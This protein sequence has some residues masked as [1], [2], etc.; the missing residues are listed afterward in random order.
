MLSGNEQEKDTPE[1]V[2]KSLYPQ[3]F[4]ASKSTRMHALN[5]K[6]NTGSQYAAR[7]NLGGTA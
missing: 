5:V 1:P 2:E 6:V 4:Q 7:I 3:Q